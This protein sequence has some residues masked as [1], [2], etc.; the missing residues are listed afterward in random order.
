MWFEMCLFEITTERIMK[1]L[2][3]RARDLVKLVQLRLDCSQ[4]PIFP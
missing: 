4:S 3:K 2:D 1:K